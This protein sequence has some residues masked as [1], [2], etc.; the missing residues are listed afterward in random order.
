MSRPQPRETIDAFYD[1]RDADSPPRWYVLWTRS[2]CEQRVADQLRAQGFDAFLPQVDIW[3]RRRGTRRLIRAPMFPGYVFLHQAITRE[4]Y[5]RANRVKGMVRFLGRGWD[6]LATVP[7]PEIDGIRAA[8]AAD[9]PRM[10]HP[11]LAV[12]QRVRVVSGPLADVEG[13]LLSTEA[14]SGLLI[15]S[16]E[17]LRQSVAVR[18]DCTQAVPA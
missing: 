18:I 4:A 9:L 10:P 6:A 8:Q 12:G 5:L 13:I 2:N 3:S 16:I 7:D 14:D 1:L 11:Y 15:L 17:L